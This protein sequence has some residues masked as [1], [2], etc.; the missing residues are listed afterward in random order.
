MIQ[1]LIV[2]VLLLLATSTK[3]QSKFISLVNGGIPN[4][5]VAI[6]YAVFL[7]L[8]YLLL[9]NLR[10][11]LKE[12]FFFEVSPDLQHCNGLYNGACLHYKYDA[13]GHD[14]GVSNCSNKPEAEGLWDPNAGTKQQAPTYG[15][16]YYSDSPNFGNDFKAIV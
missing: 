3:M 1:L 11:N 14:S 16:G 13:L 6:A 7:F 5:Y 4:D 8:L 12:S 9:K 2:L 15:G 10:G